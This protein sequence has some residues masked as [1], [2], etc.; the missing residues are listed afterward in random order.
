MSTATATRT[1]KKTTKKQQLCTYITLFSTF[2]CLSLRDYD[3]K[4]LNSRFVENSES[5]HKT[6]SFVFF[7][8]LRYSLLI[9][10]FQKYLPTFDEL[11]EME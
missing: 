2:L 4:C 3:V 6:V 11:K 1:A 5:E 8:E 7:P 9:N 10:L